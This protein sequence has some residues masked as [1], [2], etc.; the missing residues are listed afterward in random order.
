MTVVIYIFALVAYLYFL[1]QWLVGGYF[2]I[3]GDESLAFQW[4][5]EDDDEKFYRILIILYVFVTVVFIGAAVFG[6]MAYF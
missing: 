1:A 3:A 4:N 5:R 2:L 6:T